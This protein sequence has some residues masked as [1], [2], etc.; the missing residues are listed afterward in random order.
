MKDSLLSFKYFFFFVRIIL[1]YFLIF[2]DGLFLIKLAYGSTKSI[3]LI[4]CILCIIITV[5]L[6]IIITIVLYNVYYSNVYISK[7]WSIQYFFNSFLRNSTKEYINSRSIESSDFEYEKLIKHFFFKRVYYAI[8]KQHK[9][10]E[11]CMLKIYNSAVHYYYCNIRDILYTTL[12][13][14]SLFYWRRDIY[15]NLWDLNYV[16]KYMYNILIILLSCSYIDLAIII[17]SYKNSSQYIMKFQILV[18]IIFSAPSIF[19]FSE[20]LFFYDNKL[21]IFFILGCLKNV[22]LFLNISYAI[23]EKPVIFTKTEVKIIRII[24]GVILICNSFASVMYTIQSTHPYKVVNNNHF[25]YFLNTYIDY[26]YFSII[27][28]STVGYGDM[29]PSNKI[30]QIICI[31]YIFTSF[32]WVPI[33]LNDLIINIFTK[34]NTYGKLIINSQKIIVLIGDVEPNQ[35]NIFFFESLAHGNKL[36]FHILTTYSIKCYQEQINIANS[37]GIPIYIKNIDLNE[38]NNINLLYSMN[39]HNAYCFFVF[40]AKINTKSYNIDT[41]SFTR[42]LILK[43]FTHENKKKK[44]NVIIVL[45]DK[46]VSNVIKS[47]GFECFNIVNLKY[48][49]IL[50]NI[51]KPGFITLLLNLFTAYNL[52]NNAL[53]SGTETKNSTDAASVHYIQEFNTGAKNKI[54][55]FFAHK[56]MIGITYDK[57]YKKLFTSL[58]IILI[59]IE[60]KNMTTTFENKLKK[61]KKKKKMLLDSIV[62]F[63]AKKKKKKKNIYKFK[64]LQFLKKKYD[65]IISANGMPQINN[66]HVPIKQVKKNIYSKKK[67]YYLSN[68]D[69]TIREC[70]DTHE[71][72]NKHQKKYNTSLYTE[73]NKKTN[74]SNTFSNLCI[75]HHNNF[76]NNI[77]RR[78]LS[79]RNKKKTNGIKE[80]DY[81]IVLHK[82][83]NMHNYD[84]KN[85]H[86]KKKKEKRKCYLNLLGKNYIINKGDKCLIIASSNKVTKYLS[87]AKSLFWLF[88]IKKLKKKT[89]NNYMNNNNLP[90]NLKSVIETKKTFNKY[91]IL[92]SNKNFKSKSNVNKIINIM[93]NNEKKKKTNK[94]SNYKD[95]Y[96]IYK[97]P[98]TL[99]KKSTFLRIYSQKNIWGDS[100]VDC[101]SFTLEMSSKS[102]DTLIN[103]KNVTSTCANSTC[104]TSTC[105]TSTCATRTSITNA[106]IASDILNDV[107]IKSDDQYNTTSTKNNTTYYQ[108]LFDTNISNDESINSHIER[109][110]NKVYIENNII[111]KDDTN[112]DNKLCLKEDLKKHTRIINNSS[113]DL[114]KYNNNNNNN[115][116]NNSNN[117]SYDSYLC[118]KK[119]CLPVFKKKKYLHYIYQTESNKTNEKESICS[120]TNNNIVYSYD[121][122]CKK[123][124]SNC[125]NKK[126]LLLINYTPDIIQFIKKINKKYNIIIL[127]EEIPDINVVDL[128]TYNFVF[129]KCEYL[130][131]YNLLNA[132]LVKAEYILILPTECNETHEMNE[133]DMY[134]IIIRRKII[135]LLKKIKK[136]YF[137][138]NIITELINPSNVIF[139]E[140]NAMIKLKENRSSY[141]DFFPYINCSP[142]YASN[143]ICE[144]MLY[145]FMANHKSF[146]KY[147]VCNSTLKCLI[148]EINIIYVYTLYKYFDFSL[149]KIKTFNELFHFLLT[150]NITPIGLYRKG[151]KYVPYYI[152]TKPTEDCALRFDDIIY[153]L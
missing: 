74:D 92:C 120:V 40:S 34:K 153:I 43:K 136:T 60:T 17:L 142:F 6:K 85:M 32:I 112:S 45:Q 36:K 95:L 19:F 146:N 134:N 107:K 139:L 123:H 129:I 115:N 76:S 52:H 58:G 78:Q 67:L 144:N 49:L 77:K 62:N 33:Q 132:G 89:N 4:T 118:Y 102:F 30:S 3:P 68:V 23:I 16:P 99:K 24:L 50:K 20:H 105:M 128:Y 66:K 61:K 122:A 81:N 14:T 71:K 47:I 11:I 1:K 21:D 117:I 27:S 31:L 137:V 119:E 125:L 109:K 9:K 15:T 100:K 88:E 130:D 94:M 39:A 138:N 22:K 25:K 116:N 54:F 5:T 75:N 79:T 103:S 143:L 148:K 26:I 150:I 93:N 48:S 12:W 2:I 101:D 57:L 13:Y 7:K 86:E 59:G 135:H 111:K 56:N 29:F 87:R 113:I 51:N 97:T 91:F 55:S 121:E 90:Y 108:P 46:Y 64:Y 65:H 147:A 41:K 140:E 124:F 110:L 131:D 28:I 69:G 80:W 18:D 127:T 53:C 149:K 63:Y 98:K 126:L 42:L 8:K 145:N 133:I 151:N 44:K 38:K 37:F 104:V 10:F 84:S 141:N 70:A 106:D 72:K 82:K 114:K 35:L 152:Y 96:N 73:K 83:E